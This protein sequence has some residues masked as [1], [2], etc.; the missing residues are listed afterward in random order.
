MH[1]AGAITCAFVKYY[2]KCQVEDSYVY[3]AVVQKL[4]LNENVRIRPG[5]IVSVCHD[6]P[7]LSIFPVQ[8]IKHQVL[9]MEIGATKFIANFP[10]FIERE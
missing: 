6:E 5:H 4:K 2:L 7:S 8:A 9:F 3:V 10:N 1:S